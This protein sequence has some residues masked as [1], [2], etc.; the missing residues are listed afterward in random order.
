MIET[1]SGHR[2]TIGYR[3]TSGADSVAR[4]AT[5]CIRALTSRA[6]KLLRGEA[7]LRAHQTFGTDSRQGE[8]MFDYLAR[9]RTIVVTGPQRSGTTIAAKMIAHDLQREHIDEQDYGT[10]DLLC[11]L[12][13]IDRSAVI[14]APA[15]SAYCHLLPAHVAVVFMRR[16]IDAIQASQDRALMASGRTWTQEEEPVEL[17]KY[18]CDSGPIAAIKYDAWDR[19]Q[20]ATMKRQGKASFDLNYASL[21]SHPLWVPPHERR[22]WHPKQTHTR[23]AARKAA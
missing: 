15:L 6:A 23:G 21:A 4:M 14:Q 1:K 8:S 12:R 11:F 17:R 19:F 2:V 20:K 3:A 5:S 13:I 7:L 18:F 9:F 10:H 22:D 16:E